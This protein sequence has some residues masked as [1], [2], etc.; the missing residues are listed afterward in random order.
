MRLTE[1]DIAYITSEANVIEIPDI[2]EGHK[3]TGQAINKLGQ[4]EYIEQ[5]LNL[6][7]LEENQRCLTNFLRLILA[8]EEGFYYKKDNEIYFC[9]WCIR[10]G[11]QLVEVHPCYAVKETTLE[12]C[13]Y[14]DVEKIKAVE[15]AHY[16]SWKTCLNVHLKDYGK[17]WALTKEELL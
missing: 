3:Y 15:D 5:K 2:V 12:S 11:L 7:G 8:E 13:Y 14:G 10:V 4:L 9:R 6:W 1:K 16:W 17:T